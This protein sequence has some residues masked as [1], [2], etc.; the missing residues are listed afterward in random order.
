MLNHSVKKS[1]A[2]IL[3]GIR[4]Q[5]SLVGFKVSKF[6]S[7]P[8]SMHRQGIGLAQAIGRLTIVVCSRQQIGGDMAS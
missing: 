2:V 4:R 5:I 3:P 6:K 8:S 7:K 1:V